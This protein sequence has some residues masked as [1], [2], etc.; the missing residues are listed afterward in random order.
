MSR[1]TGSV[2]TVFDAFLL[3]EAALRGYHPMV[4]ARLDPSEMATIEPGTVVIFDK[5]ET[6]MTRWIDGKSWSPSRFK[7]GFFTYAQL[8][9]K[10]PTGLL[11]KAISVLAPTGH[12]IHIISYYTHH[13]T[14]LAS[15]LN[16]FI[17]QI[18]DKDRILNNAES[19]RYFKCFRSQSKGW[20][21][22]CSAPYPI[23]PK[24]ASSPTNQDYNS[25]SD[26]SSPISL[27]SIASFTASSQPIIMRSHYSFAEDI[28][29]LNRLSS[30]L[31]L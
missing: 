24:Q 1:Y 25:L 18:P 17:A 27:P 6:G 4:T 28:R 22:P 30:R 14:M 7:A 21:Q 19:Y 9:N 11:K 13:M 5:T 2:D 15:P 3:A 31:S 16:A 12:Q 20:R 26:S 29:Q 10:R 8:I 23:D